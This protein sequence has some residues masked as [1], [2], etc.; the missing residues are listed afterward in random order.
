MNL[1]HFDLN[2]LKTLSILLTEKN[3]TRA[4]ERLFVTQQAVSS[5]LGR[6][7]QHF[8]DELLVRIGRNF[9]LTPLGQSLVKPVQ[10]ALHAVQ[11]A[12]DTQP[13]FDPANVS[14][15]FSITM[16]D[17][18][19]Q[20]LLPAIVRKLATAA[21][22]IRLDVK[23]LGRDSFGRIEH[24]QLDFCI[25]AN[26]WRLYGERRS[27]PDIQS[28]ELFSDDFVCVVDEALAMPVAGLTAEIYTRLA[29]SSVDFGQGIFTLVEQAWAKA[30]LDIDVTITVPTFS[31]LIWVLPGTQLIATAQRRLAAALAPSLN[32]RVLECPIAIPRLQ[33]SLFWH[34]RNEGD[35]ASQFLIGIIKEASVEL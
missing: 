12:L 13:V 16:T 15:H 4:S 10:N 3:V 2:L 21:P 25:T 8:Q 27:S 33:E 18:A 30:E 29:H 17:Y 24:G 14:R 28:T 19:I 22:G 6:L 20:V 7:R 23:P 1:S 35:P 11:M 26:D 5:A 31:A 9:E 32:L 34:A